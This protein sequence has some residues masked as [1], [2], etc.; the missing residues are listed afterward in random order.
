MSKKPYYQ[1]YNAKK[2]RCCILPFFQAQYLHH[3]DYSRYNDGEQ[4][5]VDLLPVSGLAHWLLHGVA[6]GSIWMGKAVT[7]QNRLAKRLG[8]KWLLGYPNP[9]QRTL[10]AWGRLPIQFKDL[11]GLMILVWVI[12]SLLW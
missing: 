7:R 11:L 5:W 12:K 6:G 4:L 2:Y 10:H 1:R 9:L 8:L 3:T